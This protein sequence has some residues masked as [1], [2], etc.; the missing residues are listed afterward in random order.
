MIHENIVDV[1]IGDFRVAS[2]DISIKYQSFSI[3]VNINITETVS[4]N[5]F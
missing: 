2:A 1:V 4:L 3:H 5:V